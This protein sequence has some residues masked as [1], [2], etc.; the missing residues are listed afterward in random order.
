MAEDVVPMAGTSTMVDG[1]VPTSVEGS[2]RIVENQ[3][4][5]GSVVTFFF[6]FLIIGLRIK[7]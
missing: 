6:F 7:F 3:M 2:S 1:V 5:V 4:P